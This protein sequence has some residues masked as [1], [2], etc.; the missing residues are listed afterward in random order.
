MASAAEFGSRGE[1]D[2]GG[3]MNETAAKVLGR[4]LQWLKGPDL[5][6]SQRSDGNPRGVVLTVGC[7]R[8]G[9]KFWDAIRC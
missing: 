9:A 1:G 3:A 4:S 7:A 6:D 8:G 2:F 5:R